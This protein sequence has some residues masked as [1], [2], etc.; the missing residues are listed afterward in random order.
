MENRVFAA[1]E[2][3]LMSKTRRRNCP[4]HMAFFGVYDGHNGDYVAECLKA[5]LHREFVH[6]VEEEAV[7]EADNIEMA[8]LDAFASMDRK[9][10]YRDMQRHLM[11]TCEDRRCGSSSGSGIGITVSKSSSSDESANTNNNN[12]GASALLDTQC[13]SGSVGVALVIVGACSGDADADVGA[14]KICVAHVGDCRAVLCVDG[15]S[16]SCQS[17]YSP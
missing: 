3:P 1:A 9:I 4:L 6:Y 8:M 15:V 5:D 2:L 14:S 11:A 13:Y 17:A 10:V 16:T 12:T 7:D